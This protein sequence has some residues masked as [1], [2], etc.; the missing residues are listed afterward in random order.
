MNKIGLGALE[1]VTIQ[2]QYALAL[3]ERTGSRRG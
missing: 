3:K 1:K 2:Q